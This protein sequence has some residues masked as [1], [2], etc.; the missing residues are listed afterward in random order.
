MAR[1]SVLGRR[2]LSCL[3]AL[4][5][6][7]AVLP[8]GA[9]PAGAVSTSTTEKPAAFASAVSRGGLR[10]TMPA[11]PAASRINVRWR[12]GAS[13]AEI[14]AAAAKLGFKVVTSS[15]LG[16][17]QLAPTSPTTAA[18]N[19][20]TA[21]KRSGLARQV[22]RPVHYT[23][24]DVTPNDPLFPQQWGL[25]NVGQQ[26]GTAGADIKA[27]VAWAQT[28]GTKDVIVAVVDEGVNYAHPDL[29]ANM[30][31]N[32]A[33]VPNNGV[34][35]DHD[36]YID[37]VR[38]WDFFNGDNTVYD[39]ADGDRHG[40]HVAGII[41]AVGD[42][43]VGTS[44][45]AQHVS[46][47]PVKFL[48]PG[49]GDDM[50]GAQAITY[51][52]DHGATAINCSWGGPGE[53]DVLDAA[54][55]YAAQH[56]VLIVAAAGNDGANLDVEQ[57]WPAASEATN[58]IS[59][60]ATDR[61]DQL[62]DF[63]NYGPTSVDLAAPG[64]EVT[65][66]L[67]A[68]VAG[69]YIDSPPYKAVYL[70]IQVESL[71]PAPG[72][73][74]LIARSVAQLGASASGPIL[75]VDDS[76]AKTTSETAG[77]RLAV[78]TGALAAAGYTD[79][80]TWVTDTQ[81]TPTQAAMSGHIVVWFTGK[82]A[83]G[84]YGEPCV[85]P[86]EA[87]AIAAYLDNG[88]RLVMASGE[89]ATDLQYWGGDPSDPSSGGGIDIVS[90]Y[91]HAQLSDLT[92]WNEDFH[93]K[94][95]TLF[96]SADAGLPRAFGSVVDNLWPTGSDAITVIPDGV[97]KTLVTTGLYGPL[98]GT[99]MATPH[100]T[101]AL[102]LLK[103]KFP[104]ASS[105]ELEARVLNTVE[106][107]PGL[108]D[109]MT[110]GGRL[111]VAAAMNGYPGTPAITSPLKGGKLHI[112][113]PQDVTWKP[114]VGGSPDATFS[115][116]L[117]RPYTALTN[118]F[119]SGTLDGFVPGPDSS[120]TWTVS[121]EAT[122]VHSGTYAAVSGD[123][124]GSIDIGD[125]WY[126]ASASTMQ[127]TIT[128]PAGGATLSFWW[129]LDDSTGASLEGDFWVD[130]GSANDM[131]FDPGS[132]QLGSY[133]LAAGEHSLNWAAVNYGMDA[134]SASHVCVDDIKL[135]AHS[136]APIGGAGVGATSLSYTPTGPETDDAWIRIRSH[137]GGVDS[138]W[139]YVKG[140]GITADSTP[141]AR[142][143]ALTA[144]PDNDGHAAISWANPVDPD[145]SR[146][147]V[148]ASTG[149]FPTSQSDAS[150]TV[151]QDGTA[152][153]GA[154]GPVAN[155]AR[156]YV[157]AWAED[158]AG[159]WS[160][161]ATTSVLAIDTTPPNPVSFVTAAQ[162]SGMTVVSWS[163]PLAGS[164]DHVTV[165][166]RTDT[167]PTVGDRRAARVFSGSGN[168]ATDWILPKGATQ[169]FYTVYATDL[170]GNVSAPRSVRLA[171]DTVAPA[172]SIYLSDEDGFVTT[173][174]VSVFADVTGATEMRL[175]T[176]GERDDEQPWVPFSEES[177]VELLPIHGTQ[178]VQAEFRD[179]AGNVMAT[180][181]EVLV[182]LRPPLAPTGVTAR[183]WN[184]GT[185][186]SWDAPDD[187]SLIGYTVYS[188]PTPL[189]PWTPMPM[190]MAS[191][192]TY[193]VAGLLPGVE[194]SF[195][196][197]GLDLL[198]R[199]GPMSAAIA[200]ATAGPGVK[201]LAGPTPADDSV[202]ASIARFAKADTVVVGPAAL[203]AE[204][205]AAS[206]LAG[207][208]RAPVLSVG[209]TLSPQVAG[210]I[211]RLGAQR[212]VIVGGP[213]MVS[214]AVEDAL[215]DLSITVERVGT[216]DRFVTAAAVARQVA[217]AKGD[218]WDGR[219]FVV[220]G[221][222]PTDMLALG[223]IA[224]ASGEPV[225]ILRQTKLHAAY[226]QWLAETEVGQ[227]IV[228]G[229]TGSVSDA[230]ARR[231]SASRKRISGL[232]R[233]TVAA[234][235]AEYAAGQGWIGWGHVGLASGTNLTRS[236]AVGSAMGAVSGPILFTGGVKIDPSA[237]ATLK[238]HAS[239]IDSVDI[240]APTSV[241]GSA[242][243]SGALASM[244]VRRSG[245]VQPTFGP[246]WPS[247]PPTP[248]VP[249]PGVPG[250]PFRGGGGRNSVTPM[251]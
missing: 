230:V 158:S 175:F 8:I 142:P 55:A 233:Y 223:P 196:V 24:A 120:S 41:G 141:P 23:V 197:S 91:F 236:T 76:S 244:A 220:S 88:G 79:V 228:I 47:M 64:V 202:T 72:R 43:G 95:G 77:V 204:W 199:E 186:V 149:R 29:A 73:D 189:G 213:H 136:F 54:I 153:V 101:G 187:P 234:A 210:E 250:F 50:A 201:R 191:D 35:D 155:G 212:V 42:N 231:V 122:C 240:F 173:T 239:L 245:P 135:V 237:A 13:S 100:V 225:V 58:V 96:A 71:Q 12:P 18:G 168:V 145:F 5:I 51:A 242:A 21:L 56:G 53:S 147:L 241:I 238:R 181:A 154:F 171:V 209:A 127:T 4:A 214:A 132:W 39:P 133:E 48:G 203:S 139:A 99:S 167:T 9:L 113:V 30:W 176:N 194:Y 49:G 206:S 148:L 163:C 7:V 105:D 180:E 33:E 90:Q 119:E 131:I 221:D 249:S 59:V 146:T 60:A 116:E 57:S 20:A 161:P 207:S 10:P 205:L 165:L 115:V 28:R 117:G 40:T 140:L 3:T 108:A 92:Y 81:G 46:I 152:T 169:A 246:P 111:D 182:I 229:G 61:N 107:K 104:S 184:V 37:D 193:Y 162:Y 164:F 125:G 62:A 1:Q 178:S 172:G 15:K 109:L 2:S 69:T 70:P 98:D 190:A 179:G 44:G 87:Q 93:G 82:M 216:D 94:V 185:R 32:T 106:R 150:A 198:D 215:N 243:A 89:I 174:T 227:A 63:S 130:N 112:G 222:A 123:L 27:A 25:R 19:I 183:S 159:N 74:A 67:P 52:V 97:S 68:E 160:A 144:T 217:D 219:V 128:V 188:A 31:L 17:V 134:I 11:G 170:S 22:S 235:L 38:G 247:G 151:V 218:Y 248:G 143:S 124:P 102:A 118:G 75:V 80:G 110:T 192:S 126:Q 78:Y 83:E 138:S 6:V 84:W 86:D 226:A 45:V 224:Y 14:A 66:T 85:N 129:K 177:T 114:S 137:S 251:F 65:S 200:T 157:S 195:K 211:V 103:A 156:I 34:D 232:T 121:T 36:G 208:L 16:W 166:R 26:G